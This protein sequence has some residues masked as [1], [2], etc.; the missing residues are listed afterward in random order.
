MNKISDSGHELIDKSLPI[1]ILLI[2]IPVI[3]NDYNIFFLRPENFRSGYFSN[4]YPL[5]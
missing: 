2:L 4:N 3:I 1:S 5:H